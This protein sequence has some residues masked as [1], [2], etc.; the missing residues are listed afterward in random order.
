MIIYSGTKLDFAKDTITGVIDEKLERS[1]LEKMGRHTGESEM[2][3]WQNSLHR[4]N[5]ILYDPEIPDNAGI[6][7][8]YNIPY[9]SKRVDMIISG[10]TEK[11]NSSA[12]VIELKQWSSIEK[13]SGKD[14]IVKTAV[15]GGIHEVTHPS[16]QAWSYVQTIEDFN[17]EIQDDGT[18]LYP[19]AFLQIC[20]KRSDD[21]LFE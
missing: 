16:Y 12:V 17:A 5:E 2:R 7:I 10:R 1:I 13:V 14:G 4:M 15:G 9:T 18:V 3:S 19:C 6:A 21:P 20:C 8:E 11:N